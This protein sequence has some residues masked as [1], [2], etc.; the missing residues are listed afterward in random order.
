MYVQIVNQMLLKVLQIQYISNNLQ[1]EIRND[2]FNNTQ[3]FNI[4]EL[5]E[6][7]K[8]YIFYCSLYEKFMTNNPNGRKYL[9]NRTKLIGNYSV[10]LI[11]GSKVFVNYNVFHYYV[12]VMINKI[13]DN[14][15]IYIF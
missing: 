11:N 8:E 5:N 9:W 3:E 2:T 4:K 12:H 13:L 10:P 1:N 7:I 14:S 6:R 15:K